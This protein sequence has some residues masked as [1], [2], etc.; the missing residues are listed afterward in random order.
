M[1][2]EREIMK[3]NTKRPL[4]AIVD[5]N[6]S[7]CR[8]TK[9]LLCFL[10]FDAVT[11]VSGQEFIDTLEGMPSFDPDCVILDVQ[12]PGLNGF[13][14]QELLTRT[15]RNIPVI[16]L[17]A[18]DETWIREQALASGAAAFLCKPCRSDVLIETLRAVL[19]LASAKEP[20]V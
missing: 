19:E 14:V 5:D 9:R 10:G 16:F 7:I 12:M 6:I 11:F 15:G 4:I 17:T 18:F 20:S 1:F 2:A 8:G 3:R 13:E